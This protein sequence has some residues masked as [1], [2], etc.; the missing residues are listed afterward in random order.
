MIGFFTAVA[1]QCFINEYIFAHTDDEIDK[2]QR[3]RGLLVEALA[4][5]TAIPEL[6]L[7]AVAAYFPLASS[8][9]GGS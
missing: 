3:L 8:S 2:A 5:G 6:W 4:S 9:K 1:Q 7:V